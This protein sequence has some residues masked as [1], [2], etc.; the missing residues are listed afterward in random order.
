MYIDYD[1]IVAENMRFGKRVNPQKFTLVFVQD[2]QKQACLF[3]RVDFGSDL[4]FNLLKSNHI[5]KVEDETLG[6][7]PAEAGVG[8]RLTVYALADLL[9]AVFDIAFDHEAFDEL[10]DVV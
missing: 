9:C 5:R 1:I 4:Y 3:G 8:D 2:A 7:F 10:F 6:L